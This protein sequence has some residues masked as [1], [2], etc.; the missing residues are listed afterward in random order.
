MSTTSPINN[1]HP[2]H[3]NNNKNVTFCGAY[4]LLYNKWRKMTPISINGIIS[5]FSFWSARD[6]VNRLK[7]CLM[8]PL[9]HCNHHTL[10]SQCQIKNKNK[11]NNNNINQGPILW[12]P[13]RFSSTRWNAPFPITDHRF[14]FTWMVFISLCLLITGIQCLSNNNDAWRPPTQQHSTVSSVTTLVQNEPNNHL[15]KKPKGSSRRGAFS[16]SSSSSGHR[17]SY[18]SNYMAHQSADLANRHKQQQS[19]VTH[20]LSN[21]NPYLN[22]HLMSIPFSPHH[23]L[24]YQHQML[25]HHSTYP[26]SSHPPS[27]T[28]SMSTQRQHQLAGN[29]IGLELNNMQ[30][31]L[32]S[33]N[34]IRPKGSKWW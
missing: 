18:S 20:Q 27:S 1:N 30:T 22:S 9:C 11:N 32:T 6:N 16:S 33:T 8:S 4:C 25:P 5:V 34:S 12:T 3:F 17:Y 31:S 23:Q 26:V 21:Y 24:L 2:F 7:S 13:S 28:M 15:L 19:T 29:K 10:D 14:L